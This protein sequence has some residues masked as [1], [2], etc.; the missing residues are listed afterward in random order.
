MSIINSIIILL[1]IS[2]VLYGLKNGALKL[3]VSL[4]GTFF[5]IILAFILRQPVAEF[6]Y[7]YL[8][9]FNFNGIFKG[10]QVLNILLYET[11]A[12]L[13]MCTLFGIILK[14]I[15][16]ITGILEKVFNATIV[17]GLVSKLIGAFL[18]FILAYIIVF[19]LLYFLKQPFINTTGEQDSFLSNIILNKTPVLTNIIDKTTDSIDEIYKLKD[20]YLKESNKD[21]FNKKVLEKFLKNNIVTVESV[22]ILKNKNK[23]NFS[24]LDSLIE[25][26]GG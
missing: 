4:V 8:P 3:S 9:F 13:I 25:K 7:K 21:E 20:D 5:V 17:L 23:L 6:L 16:K 18:G 14:I 26:Y 12:F 19:V 15:L 22:K 10:L 1:L 24:G 2:G 11:I